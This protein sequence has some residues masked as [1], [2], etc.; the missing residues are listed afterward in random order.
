ME[1]IEPAAMLRG[2]GERRVLVAHSQ[3]GLRRGLDFGEPVI[4][5]VEDGE[6][7]VARVTDITFELEDT[8]YTLELGGR[9]PAEL[10]RER[11]A[12]L[13]PAKHD[14]PLHEIVDLLHGLRRQVT[15]LSPE[16]FRQRLAP[17]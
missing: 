15:L 8:V 2:E 11:A 7:H 10:A 16:W 5:R 6:H 4:L 17:T 3:T 12:G 14:L 13:D 9:V 1:I